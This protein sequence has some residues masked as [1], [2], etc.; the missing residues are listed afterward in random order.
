MDISLKNFRVYR[1]ANNLYIKA[2]SK[3][4]GEAEQQI[5]SRNCHYQN[6]EVVV[7]S[8]LL[9]R[10]NINVCILNKI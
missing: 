3:W 2:V 1:S 4:A 7:I 10:V 9:Q 8:V 5:I 6:L